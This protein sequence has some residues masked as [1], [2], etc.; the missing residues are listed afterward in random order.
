M[1]L[2]NILFSDNYKTEFVMVNV[3]NNEGQFFEPIQQLGSVH[4]SGGIPLAILSAK[5][6]NDLIKN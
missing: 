3:H 4:P 6:A 5:I 1:G 2:H